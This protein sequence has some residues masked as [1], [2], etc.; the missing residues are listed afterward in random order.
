M[1]GKSSEGVSMPVRIGAAVAA[2][3]LFLVPA[4]A[5]DTPTTMHAEGSGSVMVTPDQASL[6]LT[7]SRTAPKSAAALSATNARIHAIVGA[8]RGLGVPASGI[9]TENVN[10]FRHTLLVGPKHHKHKIRR[11][12]ATQSLS[13]T[14][15]TSLVG[16]VIDAATTGGATNI[17][18]PDFSFSD[19]T[20]GEIAAENAA[21]SDA[22]RQADA[23]AKTL[24]YTVTGVESVDLAP[25]SGTFTSGGGS[26]GASTPAPV[27]K[28]SPPTTVHP[29]AEE[30][31]ATVDVVFTIAPAT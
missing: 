23:A 28:V 16:K 21:L 12:T 22:R 25:G 24:G 27:R 3:S 17:N 1:P 5:A 19:P 7:V 30:V 13:V 29:G 31:D 26:S 10:V 11:Y 2:A 6:S 18:G 20:A 15:A 8:I 9:Q 4:A 14:S